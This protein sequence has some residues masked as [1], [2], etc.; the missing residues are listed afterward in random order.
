[1]KIGVGVHGQKVLQR[2]HSCLP[3]Q[4]ARRV[5]EVSRESHMAV[6]LPNSF[7]DHARLRGTPQLLIDLA[8]GKEE[9]GPFGADSTRYLKRDDPERGKLRDE[10]RTR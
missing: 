4:V 2:S 1:M 7:E 6:S 5:P 8:F 9:Q 10:T 3:E